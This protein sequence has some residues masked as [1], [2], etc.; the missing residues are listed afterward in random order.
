MSSATRVAEERRQKQ[1][2]Q[3]SQQ[4]SPALTTPAETPTDVPPSTSP[5]S[6]QL[7]QVTTA[8]VTLI[9]TQKQTEET[10]TALRSQVGMVQRDLMMLTPDPPTLSA[11]GGSSSDDEKSSTTPQSVLNEIREQQ[12][13]LSMTVEALSQTVLAMPDSSTPDEAVKIVK[14]LRRDL[15]NLVTLLPVGHSSDEKANASSSGAKKQPGT[16]ASITETDVAPAI[17][18]LQSAT[19][20]AEAAAR[21]AKKAT[22]ALTEAQSRVAETATAVSESRW[23]LWSRMTAFSVAMLPVA[24]A[25]AA[26]T[27]LSG[28]GWTVLGVGPLTEWAWGSFQ[29][30]TSPVWKT[31]IAVVTLSA[32]GGLAWATLWVGVWIRRWLDE[33]V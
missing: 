11:S 19:R 21:M 16:P 9:E 22:E 5:S 14:G 12:R 6:N 8:L 33:K 30:A 4:P 24:L 28:I 18:Q 7:Q 1:Q 27:V 13:E 23:G 29:E 31:V 2:P 20:E 15:K 10:L 26:L 32:V 25:L 17:R 3:T